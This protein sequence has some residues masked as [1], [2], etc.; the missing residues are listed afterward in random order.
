M[1]R[2]PLALVIVAVLLLS[3]CIPSATSLRKVWESENLG[4]L[5]TGDNARNVWVEDGILY[6]VSVGSELMVIYDV[7]DISNPVLLSET[8]GVRGVDIRKKGD[9]IFVSGG[10]TDPISVWDV[11]DPENPQCLETLPINGH[12]MYLVGDTLYV[13]DHSGHKFISVDISDPTNLSVLDE[14]SG[15]TYFY[16]CHD[17]HVDGDYAYITNYLADTDEYG[18]VV[19]DVSDP[20][21]MSVVGYAGE[22]TKNSH[23]TKK[24][25]I[26]FT[27]SH[28]PDSGLRVWD[29]SNPASPT[30][31][32][33]FFTDQLSFGYWM[34]WIGDFLVTRG[35]PDGIHVLTLA[36][37]SDPAS[38]QVV[39]TRSISHDDFRWLKNVF[40]YEDY[41][42]ISFDTGTS[43]ERYWRLASYR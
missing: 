5:Q 9:Y 40:V 36:D 41:I 38:P 12:G 32:G 8:E 42:F 18:I 43:S 31:I 1:R 2:V 30:L 29:V 7:A 13:C 3:A 27:G 21:D 16:G 39:A 22:N 15:T 26:V 19:V 33:H 11:S 25:D 20:S 14:L 35:L 6:A 37:V 17:V 24:G 28:D 23:V 4:T 10:H 34:D